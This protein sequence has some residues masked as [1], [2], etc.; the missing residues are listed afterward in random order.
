MEYSTD[1]NDLANMELGQFTDTLAKFI[2][3]IAKRQSK[4][5][6]A[7]L[8]QPTQWRSPERQFTDHVYDLLC[9]VG[10]KRLVLENRVSCPY[11]TEQY[12]AQQVTWAKEHKKLLVITRE[13]IIWRIQA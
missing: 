1:S 12:N 11:A 7:L 13:L 5:V 10:N 6:I 9:A 4:G 8:I 3:D 2:K